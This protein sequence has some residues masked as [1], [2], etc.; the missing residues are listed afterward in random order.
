MAIKNLLENCLHLFYP[1]QCTGCGSD[2]LPKTNMLCL[3]CLHELPHTQFATQQGNYVENI[4]RGRMNVLAA[5]SEFFFSK[6]QLVQHLIHELKYKANT[7]IGYYLGEMIGNNI[8][9]SGRFSNI[10][11][12]IPLP[13]YPDKE[14]KRGY[15][16]SA[17]ICDG[18][19]SS[20]QIPVLLNNVI[21]RR[22]TETQTRKHRTERWNNVD[23]SFT[24]LKPEILKGKNIL[25]VDDVITTGAS[26]EACGQSILQ[27]SGTS[28][29]VAALAHATK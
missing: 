16:Q 9:L 15:N 27:V 6:G 29:C 20:T 4:F 7:A 2:L 3:H 26:I 10:D 5:H 28:L 23:G 8:L 13:L 17:I 21:R 12:L 19:Q 18:I 1:H 22:A 24:V 25:L 14:A 11:Y